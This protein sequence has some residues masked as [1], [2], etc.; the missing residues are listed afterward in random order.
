MSAVGNAEQTLITHAADED[1]WC[2]FH[3]RHFDLHVPAG[4]CSAFVMAAEFI[5]SY[6][7]PQAKRLRVTYSRPGT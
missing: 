3:L 6:R 7:R 5:R 1:G 2:A 4:T